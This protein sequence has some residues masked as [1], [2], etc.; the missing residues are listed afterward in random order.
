VY[1]HD[2]TN[3]QEYEEVEESEVMGYLNTSACFCSSRLICLL[4][5]K[6]QIINVL[7]I[8][9]SQPMVRKTY[10]MHEDSLIMAK[11]AAVI[12][13]EKNK[14]ESLK[15]IQLQPDESFR[16]DTISIHNAEINIKKLLDLYEEN[17][18][19]MTSRGLII[20]EIV[21]SKYLNLLFELAIT[22]TQ[23]LVSKVYKQYLI[24]LSLYDGKLQI[25][26]T[27]NHEENTMYTQKSFQIVAQTLTVKYDKVFFWERD[28]INIIFLDSIQKVYEDPGCQAGKFTNVSSLVQS[29]F[30]KGS[31]KN[32]F[33]FYHMRLDM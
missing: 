11:K 21:D 2:F 15:K 10:C 22:T 4:F 5:K 7:T 3:N 16:V 12:V 14:R 13:Y 27:K 33:S 18:L 23:P 28:Q 26:D 32:C 24:T 29:R 17:I 20:L 9:R 6:H 30:I 31:F 1:I 8:S 25:R 19:I